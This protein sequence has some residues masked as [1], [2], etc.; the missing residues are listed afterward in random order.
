[1]YKIKNFTARDYQEEISKTAS[2]N[3]TLVVLPTGTGK[4]SIAIITAIKKLEQHPNSNILILTPTKPLAAQI[5]REFIEKTTIPQDQIALLTG[6]LQP[7]KRQ[8]LWEC[9]II[10][11]ATPQ[12]IQ[13]DLEA[14]RI[15]LSPTS[16][17]VIDECHKSRMNF[18]NT[19]V[20]NYYQNQSKFPTILALTASPGGSKEKIEEI[21]NN[22]FIEAIEIRTES[23]IKEFIQEKNVEWLEVALP[24][25]LRE[26]NDLIKKVYKE[27]L[28]DLKKIGF[29]K[30]TS[31]IS[32]K[33]LLI[34]QQKLIA[35][36]NKK[37]PSVFYGLSLIA[38]L[39][40]LDYASELVETQ[41]I[42]SLQKFLVKLETD[43]TKA[44]KTILNLS[45][46]QKAISITNDLVER[47]VKHPKLYLLKGV[48]KKEINEN[49]KAKI[50]VFA[51]YRD[52]IDEILGFLNKEKDIKAAKLIGQKSGLSQKEQI[53]IVEQF[54]EGE[55]NTLI[56][57]SIGE[58][59]LDIKGATTAVMYDQGKS[60]EIRKI[61]RAGRVARLETGKIISLLT[62]D[63]REVAYYWS[64]KRKENQMKS[65]LTK[66]QNKDEQRELTF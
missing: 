12:T 59:G 22:L 40:K 11:V 60:S 43:Q 4:T 46:I 21:K 48:I 33:D 38:S 10:T 49:K 54:A 51:N 64:S 65:I 15:S 50:I 61:Q 62:K 13:K 8:E 56:T 1:M 34:L 6:A 5:Q 14:R 55:Y 39:I 66:M 29:T 52:T 31:V 30:P 47:N 42:L 23:D 63:T 26:V 19:K 24:E 28:E 7:K 3:N 35:E 9:A 18:A 17:L 57:S 27:K 53:K 25:E 41:G 37:N 16:L 44:S 36:I 2:A 20:A 45:E 58:E 32:K